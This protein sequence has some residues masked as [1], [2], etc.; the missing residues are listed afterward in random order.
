M[1]KKKTD[2]TPRAERNAP[3]WV[4][5]FVGF[6]LLAITVWTLPVPAPDLRSGKQA[7][8]GSD[9]ILLWNDEYLRPS[10]LRFYLQATGFWQYWDM[11]SP[12]PSSI[13][14]WSDAIVTY[15]DG[16]EIRYAY[17]RMA[18]LSI[19]QKFVKERYRK[20]YERVPDNDY[21]WPVV[22]QRIALLSDTHPGNPPIT[23]KLYHHW[24]PVAGPDQ[25][26]ESEYHK[27]LLYSHV[28]DLTQLQNAETR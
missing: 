23:V 7:P 24:R 16:T 17:P 13:D 9:R 2:A 8:R 15:R 12:E 25:K 26:Q 19:P 4:K 22:A 1:S 5:L 6:H 28:V 3:I 21:L 27:R 18:D 20:F 11:F 10:P 14:I